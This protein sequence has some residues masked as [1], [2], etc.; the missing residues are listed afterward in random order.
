MK[1]LKQILALISL[2]TLGLSACGEDKLKKSE[3]ATKKAS[4]E[5]TKKVRLLHTTSI[6]AG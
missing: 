1:K 3:N 2:F 5:I 6:I 4:K